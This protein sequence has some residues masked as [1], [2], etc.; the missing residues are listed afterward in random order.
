MQDPV[1]RVG[2]FWVLYSR[3][4]QRVLVDQGGDLQVR[5]TPLD[6]KLL[7]LNPGRS[8]RYCA[9]IQNLH[10]NLTVMFRW[11]RLLFCDPLL[12][13]MTTLFCPDNSSTQVAYAARR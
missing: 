4:G 6:Q 12:F 5:P 11:S 8:K 3:P 1:P 10:A 2:K 9:L 13:A 7:S